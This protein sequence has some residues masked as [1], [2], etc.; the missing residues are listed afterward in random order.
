[1][2][3][4]FEGV[5]LAATLALIPVLVIESD[6]HSSGWQDFASVMNWLIWAIFFAELSFILAVAP[7]K[8]AALRAH[9]LDVVI[10]VA[11]VPVFG[12]LLASMRLLRLARLLRLLRLGAILTRLIQRERDVTS[13]DAF[14]LVALLTVL[15]V[16]V[17]GAVEALVDKGDFHSTWDGIWWAV[18]TVTTVGYGDVTPTSVQGRLVAMVVM[19]VGIGF[20]SVLTATFASRFVKSER[21]PE[22]DELLVVLTRIEAE[23]AE[24]KQQVARS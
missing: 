3:H 19:L 15:I 11:T 10:V 16:V 22:H 9:W 20:I 14:R 5:V 12:R 6:A 8:K 24:L 2:I 17:A 13:G 7:R 1:M 18:V 4:R 21:S 23:L